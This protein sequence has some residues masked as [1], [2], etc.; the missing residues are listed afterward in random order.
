MNLLLKI[1]RQDGSN[2]HGELV[3]FP[4][5]DIDPGMSFLELLDTVNQQLVDR[6][7]R[8]IEFDHDCR[9]GI[10]GTCG[11]VIDGRP[12][13]P[14]AGT[15]TCQLHMRT[16]QD[17]DTITI[18]PFRAAAF[19]VIRD[20]KVDR[21]KLDVIQQ[22]GGFISTNVATAPE[23]NSILIAKELADAAFDAAACIGCGA[24]VASCKN[25]SARPA[26]AFS[27]CQR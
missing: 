6:G 15:T 3:D 14:L 25:A 17:G 26:N 24:C 23:A 18:E 13:G 22:A 11:L 9:E 12:H 27:S 20:L 16:F 1:W 4:V 21:S 7:E 8:V 2:Q 10:C 19:P 5:S